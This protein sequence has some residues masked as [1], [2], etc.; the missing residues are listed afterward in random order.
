MTTH[1]HPF[2]KKKNQ[3]HPLFDKSDPL[4]PIFRQK[5]HT[6]THFSTKQPTPTQFSRKTTHYH[7]FFDKN[8]P[9]PVISVG[10]R[11]TPT[12]FFFLSSFSSQTLTI[13]RIA[14]KGRGPFF[15]PLY[16]FHQ[17]TNIETFICNFECEMTITYF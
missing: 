16:H 17:L 14:G 3:S 9:F 10:K 2:F 6:P 12:Q 11:P 8:V 5:R 1:S 4:P 13:H 7:P 15:I